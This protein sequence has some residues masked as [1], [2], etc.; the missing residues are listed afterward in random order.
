MA[1]GRS[2]QELQLAWRQRVTRARD[3]YKKQVAICVEVMAERLLAFP[4]RPVPDPD[5]TLK[6][7]QALRRE[8]EALKEY[9]RVV[10]IYADLLIHG[11]VPDE[12]PDSTSD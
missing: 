10:R 3:R 8:S 1:Q 11:N 4:M 9:T 5:G 2:R 6:L 12:D 7:S